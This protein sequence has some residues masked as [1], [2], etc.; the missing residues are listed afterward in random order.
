MSLSPI[1][2]FER[3][4][5]PNTTLA[6]LLSS[7]A[8]TGDIRPY[9]P[10][11]AVSPSWTQEETSSMDALVSVDRSTTKAEAHFPIEKVR[12][13]VYCKRYYEKR[14]NK[15]AVMQTERD[16]MEQ[17]NAALRRE[18]ERLEGFLKQAKDVVAALGR[19]DSNM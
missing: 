4:W 16:A 14:K 13:S 19:Q 3:F 7:T 1:L 11:V 15:V 2:D 17:Q 12:N 9:S 8:N 18:H 6:P 5:E 10:F